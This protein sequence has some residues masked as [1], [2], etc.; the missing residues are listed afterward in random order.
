[1]LYHDE[2]KAAEHPLNLY[3]TRECCSGALKDQI[4]R[5]PYAILRIAIVLDRKSL[6]ISTSE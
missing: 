6:K 1:M 4:A 5:A 3:H 2:L